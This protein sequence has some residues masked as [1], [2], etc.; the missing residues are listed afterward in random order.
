MNYLGILSNHLKKNKERAKSYHVLKAAMSGAALV[1]TADGIACNRES[2]RTKELINSLDALSLYDAGLGLRVY[3]DAVSGLN[4]N[5]KKGTADAMEAISAVKD[6]PDSSAMVVMMCQAVSE[7]D[8]HIEGAE[9]A[10]IDRI[11]KE[12]GAEPEW[13]MFW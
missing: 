6:D 9:K 3:M 11:I 5:Q 12:L 2:R 8:G 7:A 4:K 10:S 13:Y 1:A